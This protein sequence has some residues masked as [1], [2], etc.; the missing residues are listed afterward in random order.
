[1]DS[2]DP[3][4][5]F[6]RPADVARE[7]GAGL[8]EQRLRQLR[9]LRAGP[10]YCK[11]GKSVFYKRSDVAEWLERNTVDPSKASDHSEPRSI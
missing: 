3:I 4:P 9:W 7:F 8:T 11:A 6:I 2:I 10:A 1:M 5:E